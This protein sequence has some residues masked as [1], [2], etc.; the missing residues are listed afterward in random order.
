MTKMATIK[1][2]LC[3]KRKA[4]DLETSYAALSTTKF[5]QVMALV[6]PWTILQQGQIW[7]PTVLYG[8]KY[9]T[10]DFSEPIVVY[11]IKVGR[12]SQVDEY[13]YM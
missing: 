11:D 1:N 12:C 10:I 5:V 4:N 13:M 9:K 8:T 3:W 7:S 2:L 6:W